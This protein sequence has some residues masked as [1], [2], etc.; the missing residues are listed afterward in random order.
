MAEP[1]TGIEM[2]G[3]RYN[4]VLPTDTNLVLDELDAEDLREG[5][6][7]L[8]NLFAQKGHAHEYGNQVG[9]YGDS[10]NMWYLYYADT[11]SVPGFNFRGY[12]KSSSTTYFNYNYFYSFLTSDKYDVG[13][14]SI[15]VITGSNL[16]NLTVYLVFKDGKRFF[17]S[18]SEIPGTYYG[19]SYFY[20]YRSGTSKLVNSI[21]AG[22]I[23][24][25]ALSSPMFYYRSDTSATGLISDWYNAGFNS[26]TA[27]QQK[28]LTFFIIGPTLITINGAS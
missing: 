5:G 26:L 16:T 14:E 3:V 7:N 27:A 11:E 25:S 18:G 17:R 19:V 24:N 6:V 8:Y 13:S 4:F 23:D 22:Y 28:A 2:G 15:L 21:N 12:F 1:I 10:T 20:L 9:Y